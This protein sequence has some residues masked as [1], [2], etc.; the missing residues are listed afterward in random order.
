LSGIL[1]EHFIS[2]QEVCSKVRGLCSRVHH[3]HA[4]MYDREDLG[5]L[6]EVIDA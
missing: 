2:S 4:L 3:V 6:F 5:N 1:K